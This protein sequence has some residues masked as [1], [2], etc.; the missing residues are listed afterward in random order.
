M[1][2]LKGIGPTF[3]EELPQ[4]LTIRVGLVKFRS[5]EDMI[6]RLEIRS[7]DRGRLER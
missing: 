5:T 1:L 3:S 7:Q 4:K 6:Q 2:Q